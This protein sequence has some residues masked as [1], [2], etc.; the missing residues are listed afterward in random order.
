MLTSSLA[1]G[2]VIDFAPLSNEQLL[3]MVKNL[4]SS[5]EADKEH[6]NELFANVSGFAVKDHEQIFNPPTQLRPAIDPD[7]TNWRED[8]NVN[9]AHEAKKSLE[10]RYVLQAT[11]P[12]DT[13]FTC[14]L[15]QCDACILYKDLPARYCHLD[16]P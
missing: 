6:L 5:L 8:T 13:S 11:K 7:N 9:E 12:C 1:N 15:F 2:A 16:K 4:P 14:W 10:N 3:K